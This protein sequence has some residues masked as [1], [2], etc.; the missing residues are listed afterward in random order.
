MRININDIKVK[1][2][3]R[4]A[5]PENV[6]KLADSIKEIG[7]IHPVTIDRENTLVAGL[8]R[9]NAAKSL[10][11]TEVECNVTD[12]KGLQVELAEID[13]NLARTQLS[14]VEADELLLRRKRIYEELHP[15]TR[16]GGVRESGGGKMTNCQLAPVKSFAED[17]AQKLGV[18]SRTVSRS[19]RRAK[20]MTP[21][22]KEV[23]RQSGTKVTRQNLD[24]LS[25]LEPD[26]QKEA[27]EQLTA[28]AIKSVDEYRR[29]PADD[30]DKPAKSRIT[31]FDQY[32][33]PMQQIVVRAVFFD[34]RLEKCVERLSGEDIAALVEQAKETKLALEDFIELANSDKVKNL[35]K[36]KENKNGDE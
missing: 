30:K 13:E 12:L 19:V 6:R 11:W 15:E 31:L 34:I 22:A 1:E 36:E 29:N 33:I 32:L 10:G 35:L 25:H 3:R 2:G 14:T 18:S 28:G 20:N 17:T 8:H 26:E 24:K 5:A 4:E 16:H 9:L 21:E 27:A 23:I 7:M